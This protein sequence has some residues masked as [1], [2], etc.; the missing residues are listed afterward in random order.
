MK[1]SFSETERAD[2]EFFEKKLRGHQLEFCDDASDC[3]PDTEGLS[4]FIDSK[5]DGRFLDQHP[6]LKL[7]ATRS[8]TSITSSSTRAPDAASRCAAWAQLWGSH[9]AGAY[10]RADPGDLPQAAAGDGDRGGTKV[11]L[12][13]RCVASS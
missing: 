10:L 4:I 12:M 13:K 6:A 11:S 8:T 7:I 3:A 9:G 2:E 1:I 5:I